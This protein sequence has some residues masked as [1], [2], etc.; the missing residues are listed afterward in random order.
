MH[1]AAVRAPG[2]LR[3]VVK[4]TTLGWKD[5]LQIGRGLWDDVT[6]CRLA[7][8]EWGVGLAVHPGFGGPQSVLICGGPSGGFVES[9]LWR[10]GLERP[11]WLVDQV[12]AEGARRG[13]ALVTRGPLT[14]W[15]RTLPESEAR[16][17]RRELLDRGVASLEDAQQAAE[18]SPDGL[19][20]TTAR[21]FFRHGSYDHAFAIGE[22]WRAPANRPHQA[23]LELF[24]PHLKPSLRLYFGEAL[25]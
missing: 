3:V 1:F 19:T 16:R 24:V 5:I 15:R 2:Y 14:V 17:W 23:L 6:R 10:A 4:D 8:R 25:S 9:A 21:V 12:I 22:D 7:A 20:G 18:P 11:D 13:A